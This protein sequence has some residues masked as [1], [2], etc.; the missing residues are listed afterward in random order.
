MKSRK[1]ILCI[2]LSLI[3]GLFNGFSLDENIIFADSNIVPNIKYK[4]QIQS[5]GWE[6]NYVSDGELSGTVGKAKRLEAIRIK[7]V[8]NNGNKI[9]SD[10]M[11]KNVH[12]VFKSGFVQNIVVNDPNN[13]IGN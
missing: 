5:L 9:K 6:K 12:D 1:L 11:N 7:L 8:D 3:V 2:V 10:D 13:L 4:V